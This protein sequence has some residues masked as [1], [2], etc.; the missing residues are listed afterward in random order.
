VSRSPPGDLRFS[1]T[2]VERKIYGRSRHL[3]INRARTWTFNHFCAP[4]DLRA[5]TG[6][7]EGSS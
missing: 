4:M 6:A 2:T 3:E 7:G 1:T 5:D